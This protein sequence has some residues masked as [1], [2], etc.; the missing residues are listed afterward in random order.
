[1]PVMMVSGM[2][3]LRGSHGF[4][5][6]HGPILALEIENPGNVLV[7]SGVCNGRLRTKFL[8]N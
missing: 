7:S 8:R 5:G 6:S 2:I 4:W 1:M 3:F